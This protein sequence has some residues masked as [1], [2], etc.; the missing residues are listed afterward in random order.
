MSLKIERREKYNN[1]FIILNN[2]E[3][4]DDANGYGYK[5]FC[6]ASRAK[7]YKFGGGRDKLESKKQEMREVVKKYKGI[8]KFVSNLYEWN[9]KELVRGE[10]EELEFVYVVE[11]EFGIKLTVKEIRMIGDLE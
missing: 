6:S 2:N 9:I 10:T 7:S 11:E 1:R 3:I 4:I 8:K 5:S